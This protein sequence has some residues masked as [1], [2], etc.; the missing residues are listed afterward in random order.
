MDSKTENPEHMR[1]NAKVDF[2]I[3]DSDIEKLKAVERIKNYGE[4]SGFPVYGG[5]M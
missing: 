5:K 2:M 1:D 3:S 4:F